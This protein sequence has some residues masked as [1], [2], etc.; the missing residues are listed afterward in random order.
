MT[1]N[2]IIEAI[3]KREGGYVN[4]PA[5]HGGR[6]AYGIAERFNPDAW[7]DGR[8]SIEE[9][10]AIYLKKYVLEP[11]FDRIVDESLKAHLVDFAVN[12]G[13]GFV[14]E[15]LQSVL[16]VG[17]DGKLGP[18]SLAA[19]ALREAREVNNLMVGERVK[20]LARIVVRDRTQ[21]TFHVGLV[22]RACEFLR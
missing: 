18:A 9:A 7:A 10:R 4:N 2:D 12:S 6:T 17:V 14:I 3:L 11:G 15:K 5:D 19:L 22:N 1:T 8:V 13:P 20:M 21:L 16:G